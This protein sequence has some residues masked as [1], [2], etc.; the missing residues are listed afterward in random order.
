[1]EEEELGN[2]NQ[3]GIKGKKA[4]QPNPVGESNEI[5]QNNLNRR[6]RYN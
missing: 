4:T 6:C 5:Y 2:S 3:K 1:M